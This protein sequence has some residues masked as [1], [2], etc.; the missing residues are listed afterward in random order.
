VIVGIA[1]A[2]ATTGAVG[3][4]NVQQVAGA[5][6]SSAV[7]FT[8]S[9]VTSKIVAHYT[10]TPE[11]RAG[12]TGVSNATGVNQDKLP[13]FTPKSPSPHAGAAPNAA[14]VASAPTKDGPGV[15]PK[16]TSSFAGQQGSKSTC[17]YFPKGC[18]P[19]DMA[20]AAGP[21]RVLQGVN[22]QWQLYSTSGA[23]VAGWPVSG[24]RFFNVPNATDLNGKPCDAASGSQPFLSDPRALYDPLKNRFWAAML[25]VENGLG[26]SP[27]CAHKSVYYIAVSQTGDPNGSWNVYEFEMSAG[28]TYSADYTQIGFNGDAVFFSANM[29][30]DTGPG[31]YAEVFEANKTQMENGQANFTSQG[32]RNLQGTGP[33]TTAATGP[34]LADTV[35]PVLRLD[36][37][38]ANPDGADGLFLDTV[39]GPDLMNGHF[40]SSAADACRGVVLWRMK[41]PIAHDHGGGAAKLVATYL[42]DTKPFY[43]PPAAD[44]PTCNACV[45]GNDLRISGTPV[46]R[47][48][49][50]YAA[51]GTG[52]NNGTQVVP[53]VIWA[54]VKIT[55][56]T[57]SV[58]SGYFN[59][60]GDT[61]ATYAT[62]MP[63]ANGN[64]LMI[65][66]RMGHTV[67]PEVR[68]TVRAAGDAT[69][70][71]EGRLLK[72]GEAAYRPTL[73]GTSAL[74]VCRWGDY[75][76]T[77]FDGQGRIWMA[78]EYTNPHTDPNTSPW[79][80][81]NWG[82]WIG[83]VDANHLTG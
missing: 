78:G 77:S 15:T 33:G 68:Y 37:H 82:T 14:P 1:A 50:I 4:G 3:A 73:C 49:T 23:T 18:N 26:L 72:A 55:N 69:F 2:I 57:P 17:S 48:D 27:D 24:Q 74:P 5:G 54:Q 64:V 41:D 40:C 80:G 32:F 71:N 19:P 79:Y 31:F 9:P 81:R 63:D 66:E 56:G 8:S 16:T 7:K 47:N 21:S 59:F 42:P 44:Q 75:E 53:A 62:L 22:T 38:G 70:T 13:D 65:Y 61:A 34:F 39:D 25:Q 29:F 6:T 10:V 51:F 12:T 60:G 45:D 46:F 30:N 36:P 76:A 67:R 43:F 20:L 83:A 35:Q 52:V 28:A 11:Q 58:T